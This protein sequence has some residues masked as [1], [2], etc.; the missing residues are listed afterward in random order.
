MYIKSYDYVIWFEWDLL[1]AYLIVTR[2][3]YYQI[4]SLKTRMAVWHFIDLNVIMIE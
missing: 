2:N 3:V 4:D 1:R